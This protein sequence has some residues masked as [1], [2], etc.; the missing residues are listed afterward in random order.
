MNKSLTPVLQQTVWNLWFHLQSGG[1]GP[2]SPGH[3][4]AVRFSTGG[5]FRVARGARERHHSPKDCYDHQ[6]PDRVLLRGRL[7]PWPKRCLNPGSQRQRSPSAPA[8]YAP[9][10]PLFPACEQFQRCLAQQRL[11]ASRCRGH[12]LVQ[13]NWLSPIP[14]AP[15]YRSD[16]PPCSFRHSQD[17]CI[18]E[19]HDY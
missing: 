14:F 8:S 2:H 15:E 1:G 3:R 13:H 4:A 18:R 17:S 16:H 7:L 10:Q 5:R 12:R 11:A 6:R 19:P 9:R